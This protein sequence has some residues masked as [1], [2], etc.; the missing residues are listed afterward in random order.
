MVSKPASQRTTA[1][2]RIKGGAAKASGDGKPGADRSDRQGETE[3]KLGAMR[4][5]AS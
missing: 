4:K 1:S 5:S 3:E 2:A